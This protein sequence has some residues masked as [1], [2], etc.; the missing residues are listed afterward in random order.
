MEQAHTAYPAQTLFA[1]HTQSAAAM[2]TAPNV[3]NT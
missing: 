3:E 1:G 2:S